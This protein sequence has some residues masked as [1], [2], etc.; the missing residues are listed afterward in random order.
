MDRRKKSVY[1]THHQ[2]KNTRRKPKQIKCECTL[3]NVWEMRYVM[4][5]GILTVAA[6]WD[7]FYS[8]I[9]NGLIAAGYCMAFC[10]VLMQDAA[11]L[12]DRFLGMLLPY[13]M[14]MVFFAIGSLGAG[15]VKLLSVAGAFLGVKEILHCIGG[16]IVVGAVIGGLKILI[17]TERQRMFPRRM[18]IRFALPVLC[19]TLFRLLRIMAG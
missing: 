1:N 6:L 15:D 19:G 12:C 18:T 2:S 8:R 5:T 14:G 11:C 4:L 3:S 16:A 17:E 9:P 13:L 7:S 10:H